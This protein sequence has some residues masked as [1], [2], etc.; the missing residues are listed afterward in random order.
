MLQ[1]DLI[2]SV[3]CFESSLTSAME[4]D[5]GAGADGSG[6]LDQLQINSEHRLRSENLPFD[7]DVWYPV[8]APFTFRTQFVPLTRTEATAIVHYQQR[9]YV[10]RRHACPLSQLAGPLI[11]AVRSRGDRAMLTLVVVCLPNQVLGEAHVG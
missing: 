6:A 4:R 8:M 5:D 3:R 9:R 7:I 2:F 11:H 1:F 10:P